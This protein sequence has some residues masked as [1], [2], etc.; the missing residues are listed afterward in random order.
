MGCINGFNKDDK[1]LKNNSIYHI[2][3]DDQ[4]EDALTKG[5]DYEFVVFCADSNIE[6]IKKLKELF[7]N[8]DDGNEKPDLKEY[9]E[10]TIERL[11]G[12]IIIIENNKSLDDKSARENFWKNYKETTSEFKQWVK[13]RIAWIRDVNW[14]NLVLQ[15]G[16]NEIEVDDEIKRTKLKLW[17][18]WI[19][20][21]VKNL[22]K[23]NVEY[24]VTLEGLDAFGNIGASE[25]IDRVRASYKTLFYILKGALPDV[26][27][28]ILEFSILAPLNYI[29][30]HEIP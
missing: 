19:S 28:K 1:E 23:V 21:I 17:E 10:Y 24:S 29:V 12:R 30:L 20:H 7:E 26:D 2:S 16:G 22:I 6:F 13:S 4:F 5:I 11:P 3:S 27:D 25:L 9:I 8:C 15:L 18:L 14:D